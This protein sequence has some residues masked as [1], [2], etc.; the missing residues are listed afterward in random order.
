MPLDE[1]AITAHRDRVRLLSKPGHALSV[2]SPNAT[3]NNREW[4]TR[5]NG[6]YIARGKRAELHNELKAAA[7]SAYPHVEQGKLAVVLA[8]PPGAGKGTQR[9]ALL[10]EAE[11]VYLRIDPDELKEALLI[12][13]IRDG[14]YQSFIKPEV[15]QAA[16]AE[17]EEFFPMELASLVH[18]ESSILAVQIRDEAIER[19]DNIIVDTVLS[20]SEKA[21]ALGKQ[22]ESAEYTVEIIDVEVPYET[23]EE[24]IAIRWQKSY[25]KALKNK[26]S[27][28]IKDR[29]GG[30]W[31]PSEY[32]RSVYPEPNGPTLSEVA[33][34]ALLQECLAVTRY[35]LIRTTRDAQGNDSAATVEE[36]LSRGAGRPNIFPT[37][38]P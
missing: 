28:E 32:A 11:H 38:E 20:S 22:L 30:R 35:R 7:V 25:V 13:A 4:F 29:L 26:H 34:R 21:L 33:A 12:E 18:E 16:E 23:S 1:S 17:G 31:V 6:Q 14:S 37:R 9:P 5:I 15:V 8:G 2:Q 3:V 24:R 10:G 19:G 36:D 27:T